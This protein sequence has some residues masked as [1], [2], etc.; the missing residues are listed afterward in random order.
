[1]ECFNNSKLRKYLLGLIKDESELAKVEDAI[2]I[3]E[4]VFE[5]L[6]IEEDEVIE[7]YIESSLSAIE[8]KS[9]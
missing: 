8:K 1:M 6:Q 5:R 2:L 9:V 7:D 4:D 3:D